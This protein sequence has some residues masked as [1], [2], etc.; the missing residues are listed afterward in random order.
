MVEAIPSIQRLP[1]LQS[2]EFRNSDPYLGRWQWHWYWRDSWVLGRA[3]ED[4]DGGMEPAGVAFF[5]QLEGAQDS[6]G[7][8][9][10]CKAGQLFP[11]RRQG[12]LSSTLQIISPHT[13]SS[14]K[15]PPALPSSTS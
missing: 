12:P 8:P 10:A 1:S 2:P 13:T 15:D 6:P 7:H 3:Y 4:V 5:F 9:A 11:S 14:P